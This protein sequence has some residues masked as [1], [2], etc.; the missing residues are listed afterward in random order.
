MSIIPSRLTTIFSTVTM[1]KVH[2][3]VLI[4]NQPAIDYW[5]RRGW[6]RR[7]DIHVFS[8]INADNPNV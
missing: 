5:Q 2:I 6:Q 8:F 7:D 1:F 4:S 3:H